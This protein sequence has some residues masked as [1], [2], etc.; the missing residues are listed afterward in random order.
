MRENKKGKMFKK[1]KKFSNP[2]QNQKVVE[3]EEKNAC[4]LWHVR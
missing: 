2:H 1:K 4:I 3:E